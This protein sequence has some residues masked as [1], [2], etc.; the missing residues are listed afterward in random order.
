[1]VFSFP[2]VLDVLWF[3]CDAFLENFISKVLGRMFVW[4]NIALRDPQGGIISGSIRRLG[5]LEF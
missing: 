4:M 1:M 5:G 3:V 2:F